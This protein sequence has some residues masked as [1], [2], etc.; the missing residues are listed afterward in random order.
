MLFKW[1]VIGAVIGF[2]FSIYG[3]VSAGEFSLEL[4]GMWTVAGF[5]GGVALRKWI[6]RKL[7][8]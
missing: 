3:L 6:L 8:M 7:W 4:I 5:I 2:A 1:G